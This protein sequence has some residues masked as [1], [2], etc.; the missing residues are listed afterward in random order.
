MQWLCLEQHKGLL[1]WRCSCLQTKS[2][3]PVILEILFWL[4]MN[5]YSWKRIYKILCQL[6]IHQGA[7]RCK[8]KLILTWSSWGCLQSE[9]EWTEFSGRK[10]FFL[11][12][13]CLKQSCDLTEHKLQLT[14]DVVSLKELLLRLDRKS[15]WF[16]QL[17]GVLL[18][19]RQSWLKKIL[20]FPVE[21]D[22]LRSYS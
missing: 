21:K 14:L 5:Q 2:R 18:L 12:G 20:I 8:K 7:H 22:E 3:A 1:W 6:E 9:S 15:T 4:F 10:F 16:E 17:L 13:V 11:S 19:L